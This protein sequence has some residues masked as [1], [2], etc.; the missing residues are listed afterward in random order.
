MTTLAIL[1]LIFWVLGSIVFA[2]WKRNVVYPSRTFAVVFTTI[3]Y[4][5]V[6]AALAIWVLLR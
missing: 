5:L 4:E 1:A 6:F 2:D 3:L